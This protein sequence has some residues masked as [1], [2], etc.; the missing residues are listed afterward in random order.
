MTTIVK[1]P[2]RKDIQGLRAIAVLLVVLFHGGLPLSGGFAGVDVFFA[3]SGFVITQLL[4]YELQ[5]HNRISLKGFYSRRVRRLLPALATVTIATAFGSFLI[6]P[7]LGLQQ[8]AARTG[9]ATTLFGANIATYLESGYFSASSALNPYLHMWSLG[10]EEQ[11]YLAFPALLWALWTVAR[12]VGIK[13]ERTLAIG[14]AVMSL[15]SIAA[16][17]FLTYKGRV[18]EQL[19]FFGSPTR[20]WEFGFGSLTALGA[21]NVLARS[22]LTSNI[23]AITGALLTLGSSIFIDR[24][25]HFPGYVA[26]FPVFG[27]CLLLAAGMRAHSFSSVS[28]VLSARPLQFLGN[29]SYG[30]YLW[31][32]P[33]VVL[34]SQLFPSQPV[35]LVFASV[36]SLFPAWLSQ[37]RLEDPLRHNPKI[38][39]RSAVLLTAACLILPLAACAGLMLGANK[40]WGKQSNVDLLASRDHTTLGRAT[41]CLI[42]NEATPQVFEKCRWT[43]P[44]SKGVVLLAGDSHADALSDGARSAVT[45]S[46]YDFRLISGASCSFT[47]SAPKQTDFV[48][49]CGD[50]YRWTLADIRESKP[51]LVV[52]THNSQARVAELDR[53]GAGD[54]AQDEWIASLKTTLDVLQGEHIPVLLMVD[55]PRIG[56][57][58]ESCRFGSVISLTCS[59]DRSYSEHQIADVRNAELRL[60][61]GY[62]NV[63]TLDVTDAICDRTRCDPIK[64]GKLLYVDNQHLSRD[65]SDSLV[66]QLN[67]AI[68]R[69]IQKRS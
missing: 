16:C 20:A 60:A 26:I 65:G 50:L 41:G 52:I 63:S 17:I 68:G 32:W 21:L 57:L 36:F 33:A 7:P 18:A 46:G 25:M 40:G 9:L 15:V 29:L 10:V 6:Q 64:N 56:P 8:V 3:I 51:A 49:N 31:H 11:F 59:G 58:P 28:H 47:S 42:D 19:A 30:W 35:L 69:A 44:N 39:G 37:H 13:P 1:P 43:T 34:T 67:Q 54:K 4:V 12:R 27:T 45:A 55:V 2:R 22:K 62:S 24:Y 66:P 23:S 14:I 38:R 48:P 5:C 61:S 53:L